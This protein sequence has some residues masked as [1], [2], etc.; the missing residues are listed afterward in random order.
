[1]YCTPLNHL[2]SLGIYCARIAMQLYLQ[3]TNA[4]RTIIM[5]NN[6]SELLMKTKKKRQKEKEG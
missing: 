6:Y 4:L 5:D 2:F 1:M 3:G